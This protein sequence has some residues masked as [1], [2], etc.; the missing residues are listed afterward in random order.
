MKIVKLN[1]ID[2]TNSYLKN[3]IEKNSIEN[4][5]VIVTEHQT[6]GKGQFDNKWISDKGKNLTFSILVKF[7]NLKVR[8]QF[9][10]NYAISVALFN[11][12][13][14]YIPE[15]L[16]VKWPNDILSANNKVCGILIENSINNTKVKHAIIG[17]GLN[18]NQTKFPSD[19][20]N[21][22][23]LKTILNKTINKEELL[24]K[25]LLEIQYQLLLVEQQKFQEIKKAYEKILY[26]KG[27]PSMFIDDK[28]KAFLGKILGVTNEGELQVE[29]EDESIREFALKEIKFKNISK[30]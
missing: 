10:L 13:K 24:D 22:T 23:S 18:T 28:K 5:T 17:I 29:L 27:I 1:A 14:Y 25:I 4:W 15:K 20:L 19:I 2:S 30:D 16:T 8:Q 21:V 7:N 12:L 9:Y 26:K 11:V 3:L 6:K